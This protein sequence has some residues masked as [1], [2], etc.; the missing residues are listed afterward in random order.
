VETAPGDGT[1]ATG[2][3]TLARRLFRRFKDVW[4]IFTDGDVH[5]SYLGI[6]WAFDK[7]EGIAQGNR[8]ADLVYDHAFQPVH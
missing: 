3:P 5:P 4:L 1:G 2:P 6:H 7:T 8:V